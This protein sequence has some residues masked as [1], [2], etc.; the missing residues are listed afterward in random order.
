MQAAGKHRIKLHDFLKE[1]NIHFMQVR[2][3]KDEELKRHFS[4]T[5][6]VNVF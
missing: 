1:K 3:M 4:P 6:K 5:L 2:N